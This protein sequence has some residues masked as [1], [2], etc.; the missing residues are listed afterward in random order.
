MSRKFLPKAL[1][2]MSIALLAA[3]Q[4]S[5]DATLDRIKARGTLTVGVILSGAP[6]GYI[7]PTSQTQKGYNLDIAKA[8]SDDLGVKLETVTVTPPNRVQFL[9]QG[10]V[11]ILIANMQY[12]EDRAK[13]LDWV[14]T[15][16]DRSGGA[17]VGRKDSG[18][19]DWAD[20]KGKPVCVSQGSNF[21]Q[22]L[23]EQYGAEV[24]GLPSQP[25]SLLAL[26]GGNC[27]AAVHV[28]AT[29]G[30]LLEDRPEE[31]KDYTILFPT[32]LLPSDSVIWVRKGEK[33]TAEALDKS[34]RQLHTSEK[35]LEF[36]KANRLRNTDY[37]EQE[38]KTLSAGK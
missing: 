28:G 11:D 2:A 7:D 5:A 21:T 16:Y 30:L 17:A 6:F 37:L 36:A 13:V 24:K 4:A 22:P 23:I 8:L 25:E 31:W 29:V 34:I 32:E 3:T 27:V 15:P 20:L 38:R 19:K 33:E 14:A 1:L 9:Q 12:T 10:K 18:L 35:L 26:Q